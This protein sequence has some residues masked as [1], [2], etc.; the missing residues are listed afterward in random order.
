ML[1]EMREANKAVKQSAS[2]TLLDNPFSLPP[3]Q[4]SELGVNP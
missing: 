4:I 2:M 3:G 1:L